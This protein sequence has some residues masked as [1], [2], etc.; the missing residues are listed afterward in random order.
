MFRVASPTLITTTLPS[1]ATTGQIQVVT[2]G[3]TLLGNVPFRALP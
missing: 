2:P 3:G 1:S